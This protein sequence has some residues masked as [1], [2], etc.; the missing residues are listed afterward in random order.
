MSGLSVIVSWAVAVLPASY[1]ATG[2]SG[3]DVQAVKQA[4]IS[5]PVSKL[6]E[7][8]KKGGLLIAQ[9]YGQEDPHGKDPHDENHDARMPSNK[10]Q[11]PANKHRYDNTAPDDVY[12]YQY[13]NTKEPY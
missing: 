10:E 3:V 6:A 9:K 13:P 7:I 11:L 5:A 2:P 4:S 8:E 12:G 1:V